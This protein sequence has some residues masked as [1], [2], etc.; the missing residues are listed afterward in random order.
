MPVFFCCIA[1]DFKDVVQSYYAFVFCEFLTLLQINNIF[2]YVSV[3]DCV[4]VLY[5]MIYICVRV[6][7]TGHG[8]SWFL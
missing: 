5:K 6:R 2:T 7:G 4:I 8:L 3:K 1:L